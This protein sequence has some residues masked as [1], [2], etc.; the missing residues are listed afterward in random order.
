MIV[1]KFSKTADDTI[2]NIMESNS[3]NV[4]LGIG[5]SW[6]VGACYWEWKVSRFPL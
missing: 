5:L 4:F 2:G 1:A 6:L 3:V